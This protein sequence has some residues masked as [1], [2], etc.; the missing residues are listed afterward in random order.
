M[1]EFNIPFAQMPWQESGPGVRTKNFIQGDRKLRIVEF[2][3]E[4]IEPD[5]C[6]KGHSGYVLSGDMEIEFAHHG[7]RRFRTGEAL[8]IPDG[9]GSRHRHYR[10]LET[11]IL[12]LVEDC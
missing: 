2:S 1:D 10:S 11:T 9:E 7:I 4:F 3:P 5:W 12:F 8:L 6:V